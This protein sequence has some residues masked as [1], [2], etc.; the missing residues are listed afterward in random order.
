MERDREQTVSGRGELGQVVERLGLGGG[1]QEDLGQILLHVHGL[2]EKGPGF[3]V[4]PFG[5]KQMA[6][7]VQADGQV[8]V[9]LRIPLLGVEGLVHR[10]RPLEVPPRL[11][12]V[13]L[14]L[15]QVSQVVQAGGQVGV[16]L[17]IPLLG[18][19]GLAHR[20]RP[21]VIPPRLAVVAL[22]PKQA[23][24]LFRLTARSGWPWGYRSLG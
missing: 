4:L 8:G 14:G 15:K 2:L 16:A 5:L 13:P 10:Q 12:V 24:R 9:A 18:V 22:A 1:G 11:P 7:V 20:Q 17:G 21:L 6:Q 19:E 3:R 23:P